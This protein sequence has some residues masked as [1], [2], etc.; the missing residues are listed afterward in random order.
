MTSGIPSEN[1][2]RDK[3]TKILRITNNKKKKSENGDQGV[4]K[5]AGDAMLTVPSRFRELGLDVE[6]TGSAHGTEDS[7]TFSAT[8]AGDSDA[9]VSPR[10][11][12]DHHPIAVTLPT[13]TTTAAVDHVQSHHS[14][15][16]SPTTGE[17]TEKSGKRSDGNNLATPPLKLTTIDTGLGPAN[18]SARAST[19][20]DADPVTEAEM[21][22]A[23]LKKKL[24]RSRYKAGRTKRD[25]EEKAIAKA[26]VRVKEALSAVDT[27]SRATC[28]TEMNELRRTLQAGISYLPRGTINDWDL[29]PC[30]EDGLLTIHSPLFKA[31]LE[32]V[33]NFASSAHTWLLCSVELNL[34]LNSRTKKGEGEGEEPALEFE[35]PQELRQRLSTISEFMDIHIEPTLCAWKEGRC[36]E[37]RDLQTKWYWKSQGD[38]VQLICLQRQVGPRDIAE[39]SK[40]LHSGTR[41][42][43]LVDAMLI[44]VHVFGV[45]TLISVIGL[46]MEAKTGQG[47]D[48]LTAGSVLDKTWMAGEMMSKGEEAKRKFDNQEVDFDALEASG[49]LRPGTLLRRY[50]EAARTFCD[51]VTKWC[52][53]VVA[54]HWAMNQDVE[55]HTPAVLLLVNPTLLSWAK[56]ISRFARDLERGFFAADQAERRGKPGR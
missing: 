48:R 37:I 1:A 20:H 22:A 4:D 16:R 36:Q 40:F 6:K 28:I 2:S 23:K 55:M 21:L 39:W 30:D 27:N 8:P 12:Q 43:L 42:A 15:S 10:A 13:T 53:C 14:T 45:N 9:A 46:L 54:L 3:N 11:T 26:R 47:Q 18:E 41:E 56:E 38:I 35:W 7:D 5:A 33:L 31:L 24:S 17:G 52:G 49:V 44:Y 32:L 51:S 29:N 34:F 19:N 50:L 25:K